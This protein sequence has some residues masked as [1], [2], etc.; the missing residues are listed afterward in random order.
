MAR[1][2]PSPVAT[3]LLVA[4][5][6]GLVLLVLTPPFQIPDES[7]HLLR[8]YQVA[9][10]G[11][12]AES[13]GGLPGGILPVSLVRTTDA[14]PPG[15]PAMTRGE[16]LARVRQGL[17]TPLAPEEAGFVPFASA[18][19]SP[20]SYLP[21]AAAIAAGKGASLAPIALLYA[22]RLATL[23]AAT[24]LTALALRVAPAFR[25][26][27]A[28]LAL[29]PMVAF[30]RSGLSADGVTN[31]LAFLFFALVL[32]LSAREGDTLPPGLTALVLATSVALGLCKGYVVL[33]PLLLFV[34]ARSSTRRRL[35]WGAVLLG[36][37][38]A[39]GWF[40]AVRRLPLAPRLDAAV[41]AA[42]NLRSLL[43]RP[44][45]FLAALGSELQTHSLRNLRELLGQLGWLDVRL[46]AALLAAV[47]AALL[48]L[49]LADASGRLRLAPWWRLGVLVVLA[50]GVLSVFAALFV[51]HT[52]AG[53]AG[54]EGVQGRYFIPFTPPALFLLVSRHPRLAL[55]ERVS[56]RVVLLA[57]LLGLAGAAWAVAARFLAL[58]LAPTP[59]SS[60][61]L[62]S[63]ECPPSRLSPSSSTSS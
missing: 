8:A 31:A 36:A 28:L 9:E 59:A 51:L 14:F 13:S 49:A 55:S 41:D 23:L 4:L 27:L 1:K 18:P 17:A 32:R 63:G 54:I 60:R 39:G 5:P 33:L 44:G 6:A 38:A 43:S 58:P 52:P 56:A 12:L 21:A 2:P 62:Q 50:A 57:A 45:R 42:A 15:L 35:A 40:L 24:L 37:A 7:A 30:Q 46:P 61:L 16:F 3:F 11:L 34:P 47:L 53:A 48:A 29:T 10:G 22:G 26:P 19:Y 25:W 20:V